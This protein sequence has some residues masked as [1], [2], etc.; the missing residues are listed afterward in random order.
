MRNIQDDDL[1]LSYSNAFSLNKNAERDVIEEGES[2]A[3]GFEISGNELKDGVPGEKNYSLSLAQVQSFK[4]N[5]SIPSKSS[6]DQKASDL[7]GE[8]YIKLSENF[9]LKNE[10][11]I[12][13]NFNDINYNDLE[14]NLILGNTSF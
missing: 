2:I 10:F 9:N 6:L 8:A 13:H 11:S 3:T 1:K 14:A 4:E 7:V 5:S 12:D